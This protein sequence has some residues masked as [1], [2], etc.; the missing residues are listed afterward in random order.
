MMEISEIYNILLEKFGKQ[1]W[2]PI[3]T[4]GYSEDN[5]IRELSEEERF[6]ISLGAILTQN[7]AWKNVEKTLKKLRDNNFLDKDKLR[8][9]DI[10]KLA[11]IIKSSG[12]NNQKAK[13]IKE[14]IKFLDSGEEINR[15]NLLNVWGIG[16]E[17]ADSIL[18]YAYREPIFV[19]DAYTKRIMD[20]IGYKE[21]GYE[22]LQ[23]LFMNSISMDDKLFS[24]FHALFVEFGKNI[25]K[26]EP[27]CE[28][29]PLNSECD[30]LRN[31][32][33]AASDK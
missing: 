8:D 15:E 1:G 24:E 14:F 20:R 5:S 28:K 33:L 26:K 2:W 13:K 11:E 17:T 30:Y 6:E 27:L 31:N 22:E 9:I 16:K 21:N 23:N 29:C 18:L 32:S 7:M 25:C 4:R 19:V 3:L 10:K 12:Y